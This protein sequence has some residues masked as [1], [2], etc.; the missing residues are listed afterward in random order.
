MNPTKLTFVAALLGAVATTSFAAV[1]THHN[2]ATTTT[3]EERMNAALENY[4]SRHPNATVS[5]D[6]AQ[7]GPAVRTENAIKRGFHKAGDAIHRG[8]E[9]TKDAAH[10]ATH[11]DDDTAR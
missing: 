2:N 8:V 6:T 5:D 9:K 11:H 10:R 4:R 1:D 7:P 3:R